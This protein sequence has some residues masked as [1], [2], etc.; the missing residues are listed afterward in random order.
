MLLNQPAE[1]GNLA[2]EACEHLHFCIV[3]VPAGLKIL[4]TLQNSEVSV[5]GRIFFKS[6]INGTSIG[7]SSSGYVS[8]VSKCSTVYL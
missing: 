7:T 5:F 2:Q 6:C 4:C 8:K 3:Q 1:V